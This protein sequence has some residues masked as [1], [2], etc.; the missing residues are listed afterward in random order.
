MPDDV[1]AIAEV[2]FVVIGEGEITFTEL[3]RFLREG[4]TGPC[5]VPGVMSRDEAGNKMYAGD[6]PLIEDLD[7]LPLPARTYLDLSR[8]TA[9][10]IVIHAQ[11]VQYLS[12]SRGCPYGCAFCASS[13]WWGGR[14][15]FRSAKNLA[16]EVELLVKDFG[17]KGLVFREDNF[18]VSRRRLM[19][20][21]DEMIKRGLDQVLWECETRVDAV[22]LEQLEIMYQAGF[23]GAW[24]GVESG[25]Q[26]ILD[27]VGKGIN[28]EQIRTFFRNTRSVG[29]DIGAVFMLGFPD[30]KREEVHMS[31]ELG[32][33]LEPKWA[34]YTIFV[35]YPDSPLYRYVIEHG[36]TRRRW[37][38]V[39]EVVPRHFTPEEA[40]ELERHANFEIPYAL[41]EARA[42]RSK[43]P[44]WAVAYTRFKRRV[45]ILVGDRLWE[46]LERA[47]NRFLGSISAKRRRTLLEE[48]RQ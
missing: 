31:V 2:D 26:R 17:A 20:F 21:C 4:G 13:P 5:T 23:R 34:L 16:D 29:I 8:Y 10:G 41:A 42:A 12:S 11:D 36:M 24:V 46:I 6:R 18:T 43:A 27:Q 38:T 3:V 37:G 45:R 48:P 9:A 44:R 40:L 39:V 47:T 15:R 30:E 14:F 28:L 19:A 25:S 7:S 33:E 32:K 1:L 22:N 35:G